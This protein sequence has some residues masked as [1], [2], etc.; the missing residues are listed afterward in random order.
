[1]K[2]RNSIGWIAA[3]IA[4]GAVGIGFFMLTQSSGTTRNAD[5]IAVYETRDTPPRDFQTLREAAA[6]ARDLAGF[7]PVAP[8]Y[9]PGGLKIRLLGLSDPPRPDSGATFRRVTTEFEDESGAVQLTAMAANEPF[10]FSGDDAESLRES[11]PDG[12]LLYTQR[13]G[14]AVV[15]TLITAERGFQVR[16]NNTVVS[17]DEMRKV[18]LSFVEGTPND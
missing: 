1:M 11:L 8:A 9:V 16:A 5:L 2:P 3:V 15:L 4:S 6:F 10:G 14:S 18:L 7:E 13:D 17:E 12:S